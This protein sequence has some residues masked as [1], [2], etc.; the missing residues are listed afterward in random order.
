MLR[1]QDDRLVDEVVEVESS[2]LLEL[3]FIGGVDLGR[4]SALRVPGRGLQGLFRTDELVFPT[5]HLVDGTLDREELVVHAQ[6]FVNSLHDTLGV[7]A[8]VDGKA[9]GVADLLGPAA[10][11]ADAG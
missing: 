8:V 1:Q 10:E 9:A 6:L 4:K 2:G 3:L 5:A 11:N 7:V